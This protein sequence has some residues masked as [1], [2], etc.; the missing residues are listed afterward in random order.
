MFEV[1]DMTKTFYDPAVEERGIQ[2]GIQKGIIQV[3]KNLLDILEDSTIAL[4]T[5]LTVEE[6][7]QLRAD[8]GQ[9]GDIR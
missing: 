2:K 6:V 7:K 9:E 1:I 8:S 3:A 5:G 4:K